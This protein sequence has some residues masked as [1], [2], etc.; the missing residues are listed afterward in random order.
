MK[1]IIIKTYKNLKVNEIVDASDGYAKN[2]LIKKGYA[3]SYNP[4]T[5]KELKKNLKKID[6]RIA[7]EIKDSE[8][9]KKIIENVTLSF[10]LKVSK[11]NVIGSIS[12]KNVTKKLQTLDI[13]LPKYSLQHV[14]ITSLGISYAEIKL[15]Q[16]IRA[17]L[18]INVEGEYV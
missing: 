4:T 5:E 13:V 3:V 18:K 1:I 10:T 11:E 7:K 14:H 8:M 2:F 6:I 16:N 12:S 15:D 9:I 17:K